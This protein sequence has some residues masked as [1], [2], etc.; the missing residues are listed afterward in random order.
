MDS[1]GIK[2]AQIAGHSHSD[3]VNQYNDNVK[4]HNDLATKNYKQKVGQIK[5][6]DTGKTDTEAAM[7]AYHSLGALHTGYEHYSMLQKYGSYKN[8]LVQGTQH[9]LYNMSQGKLG[10][11]PKPSMGPN[12]TMARAQLAK[13]SAPMNPGR[14]ARADSMIEGSIEEDAKAGFS[15]ETAGVGE[16]GMSL[17]SKLTKKLAKGIGMGESGAHT[18]G[19]LAGGIESGVQGASL[20]FEDFSDGGKK[21]KSENTAQKVGDISGMASD[22]MGVVST[23][24]PILAPVGAV[25]SGVSMISDWIGG[26]EADSKSLS[27]AKSSYQS[28]LQSNKAPSLQSANMSTA[29]TTGATS[30]Q[31][32]SGST[33]SF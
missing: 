8:A 21:F 33:S 31:K 5:S 22:A 23:F 14:Q 10:Q 19:A 11:A 18:I 15:K 24:V 32:V 20:A 26:K 25:L 16:A 4:E 7:D 29:T 17:E 28:G 3:Y 1:Y 12:E 13:S 6:T 9:N 30:L 27:D 2:E